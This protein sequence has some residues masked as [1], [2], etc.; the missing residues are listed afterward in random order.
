MEWMFKERNMN[1]TSYPSRT[2]KSIVDSVDKENMTEEPCFPNLVEETTEDSGNPMGPPTLSESDMSTTTDVASQQPNDAS[3][4]EENIEPSIDWNDS[5]SHKGDMINESTSMMSHVV[6]C[7]ENKI[8]TDASDS[9]KDKIIKSFSQEVYV[10]TFFKF[11]LIYY[12]IF[13]Q[14]HLCFRLNCLKPK[15]KN[16]NLEV[17]TKVQKWWLQADYL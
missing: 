1:E 3:S 13:S 8:D 5:V 15:L 7:S 2:S 10:C 14:I 9:D 11:L 16:M 4:S 17:T 12:S 6:D